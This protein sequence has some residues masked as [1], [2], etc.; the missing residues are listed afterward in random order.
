MSA[1]LDQI[2]LN[3]AKKDATNLAQLFAE[4]N[5]PF[6]A[7]PDIE[8]SKA[9][10]FFDLLNPPLDVEKTNQKKSK[11][12]YLVFIVDIL[13][14]FI[15]M[16]EMLKEKTDF[17]ENNEL[18]LLFTQDSKIATQL[19]IYFS[20]L[21]IE[22]P[23][24]STTRFSEYLRIQSD[25]QLTRDE[26]KIQ[27]ERATHGV[28]NTHSVYSSFFD[29]FILNPSPNEEIFLQNH[30][31]VS[32][33]V[34]NIYYW[35]PKRLPTVETI[36]R[37][38]RKN[39]EDASLNNPGELKDFDTTAEL[40]EE[41]KRIGLYLPLIR[42][43]SMLYRERKS[44][45]GKTGPS[46]KGNNQTGSRPRYR[47]VKVSSLEL[48][49]VFGDDKEILLIRDVPQKAIDINS[50]EE[51]LSRDELVDAEYILVEPTEKEK[52]PERQ[53][54]RNASAVSHIEKYN[55]FIRDKLSHSEFEALISSI[56]EHIQ[57]IQLDQTSALSQLSSVCQFAIGLCTGRTL[58]DPYRVRYLNNGQKASRKIPSLSNDLRYLTLPLQYAY[59]IQTK[60]NK[61]QNYY[62]EENVILELPTTIRGLL[63]TAVSK[64]L[65]VH[66]KMQ[67]NKEDE[68]FEPYLMADKV[69]LKSLLKKAK[70]DQRVTPEYL[71]NF[72]ESIFY[73]RSNGDYWIPAVL[74][75]KSQV[76]GST[77]MHYTTLIN[78]QIFKI[79]QQSIS[80]LFNEHVDLPIPH[81][82][83][84]FKGVGNPIRPVKNV[85]INELNH[86]SD[87][88]HQ[89]IALDVKE[90]SSD[91]IILVLNTLMLFFETYTSYFN[92]VRDVTNPYIYRQQIDET[93]FTILADKV[94]QNGYNTRTVY[95]LDFIQSMQ[96]AFEK[97]VEDI[98]H[99]LHRRKLIKISDCYDGVLK[100]SGG[101][102]SLMNRPEKFPGF[103]LIKPGII[104][105][106][107]KR[108]KIK[109]QPYTRTKARK[110]YQNTHI[111]KQELFFKL[112]INANRHFLRS[113]LI[114]RGTNPEYVDELMGHRHI[115]TES[116]NPASLF[117]PLN[118]QKEMKNALYIL[119][120]DFKVR[121][122]FREN[123]S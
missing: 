9:Q 26:L 122:P 109:L 59:K 7:C 42:R 11:P 33:A 116:W 61:G 23:S 27:I 62:S 104:R 22:H 113:S 77:Q 98:Q 80:E 100:G 45:L 12:H 86:M 63:N 99:E 81:H 115:G 25:N 36:S 51:D 92:G 20:E 88:L 82:P 2:R 29:P 41:L 55:Q 84:Q 28:N 60:Q 78:Q 96:I 87:W 66:N 32:A 3:L 76:I 52:T 39:M 79:Y 97:T 17:T 110:Y 65:T 68:P 121:S 64:W 119:Y 90:H 54:M 5:T 47:Y 1:K 35:F 8:Q 112:A 67:E 111:W 24:L 106:K 13:D 107:G 6:A 118:Y 46:G 4:H 114:E 94:I 102:R 95:I 83:K 58:K 120:K 10:A 91:D 72:I 48:Q 75:G 44:N 56:K 38:I 40:I 14:R 19:K 21:S 103:F 93:G 71:S 73:K 69:H 37:E 15:L 123:N 34:W 101:W 108:A 50:E 57:C 105:K 85:V 30:A 18:N 53:S 74:T 49:Y 43:L 16:H 117:D 70:L 31:L 89:K